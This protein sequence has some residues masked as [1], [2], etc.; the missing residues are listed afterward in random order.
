MGEFMTI[1]QHM[2]S[3]SE[4]CWNK[5]SPYESRRKAVRVEQGK[6]CP[7][8]LGEC[9]EA[10]ILFGGG[11][12]LLFLRP[13]Q[14]D[15]IFHFVPWLFRKKKLNIVENSII[16]TVFGPKFKIYNGNFQHI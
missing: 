7:I 14:Y 12:F 1:F 16:D 8:C 11:K 4:C 5:K 15:G 6:P 13:P 3:N 2:I 10:I 9:R